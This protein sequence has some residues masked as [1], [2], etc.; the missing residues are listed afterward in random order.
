VP[1]TIAL[2]LFYIDRSLAA[3]SRNLLG[4]NDAP[5]GSTRIGHRL[6]ELLPVHPT[7]HDGGRLSA[8]LPDLDFVLQG[9]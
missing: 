6:G 3:A 8:E 4:T 5:H 1:L 2:F 9:T 7:A